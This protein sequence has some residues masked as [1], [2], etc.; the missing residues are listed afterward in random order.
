MPSCQ[1]AGD[2]NNSACSGFEV[3]PPTLLV[4][5][6]RLCWHCSHESCPSPL[7]ACPLPGSGAFLGVLHRVMG[8]V[9]Q[10]MAIDAAASQAEILLKYSIKSTQVGLFF[11][12]CAVIFLCG[13]LTCMC[14]R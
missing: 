5:A 14:G 11:C 10:G 1:P 8:K 3:V 9:L 2:F 13:K 6:H 4:S 7:P 12:C